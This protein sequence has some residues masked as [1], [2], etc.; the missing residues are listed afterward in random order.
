MG[1]VCIGL[2]PDKSPYY[3][4]RNKGHAGTHCHYDIAAGQARYDSS[5]DRS[6]SKCVMYGATNGKSA[7]CAECAKILKKVDLKNGV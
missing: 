4:D 7:F 1:L 6:N 5:S 3:Y 2:L